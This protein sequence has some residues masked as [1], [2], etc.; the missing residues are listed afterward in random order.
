[1]NK[2]RKASHKH[3]K[4]RSSKF[5]QFAGKIFVGVGIIGSNFHVKFWKS[6]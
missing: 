6:G 4:Q 3:N 1:M 5:L 2:E